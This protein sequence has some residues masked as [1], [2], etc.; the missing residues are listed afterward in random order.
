M[1]ILIEQ[2]SYQ[3]LTLDE[4]VESS[5][6]ASLF[7]VC[8]S[9]LRFLLR[10]AFFS[11]DTTHSRSNFLSSFAICQGMCRQPLPGTLVHRNER[12]QRR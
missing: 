2:E 1:R 12:H 6:C 11:S 4:F 10:F 9:P 7:S 8:S 5:T 3:W